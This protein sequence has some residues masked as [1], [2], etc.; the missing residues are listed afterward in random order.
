MRLDLF[1]VMCFFIYQ[2]QTSDLIFPFLQVYV[3]KYQE[4]FLW[5]A[6]LGRPATAYGPYFQSE[7][8]PLCTTTIMEKCG[9]KLFDDFKY[10]LGQATEPL[11]TFLEYIRYGYIIDNVVLIVAGTLNVRDIFRR[12]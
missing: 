3:F 8:G 7:L 1:F 2:Y 10:M 9:L 4:Y 6:R 12:C 5:Q 11:S